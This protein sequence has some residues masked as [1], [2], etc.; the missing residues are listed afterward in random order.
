MCS[1]P[2]F[3]FK[4]QPCFFRPFFVFFLGFGKICFFPV[5][6]G[7]F[8]FF[9]DQN[10]GFTWI[11]QAK[12]RKQ[13]EFFSQNWKVIIKF[14]EKSWNF[15]HQHLILWYFFCKMF[16]SIKKNRSLSI[17]SSFMRNVSLIIL[18]VM[19]TLHFLLV[20]L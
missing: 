16:S 5:F 3:V 15:S 17:L 10:E 8:L 7:K 13:R 11:F 2:E 9:S 20:Y 4:K 12:T 19:K 1:P 18:F 6:F 14:K